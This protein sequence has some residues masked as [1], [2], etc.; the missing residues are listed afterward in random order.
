MK[1]EDKLLK[2]RKEKGLSQE[3]VADRLKVSRQTISKWETGQ[4]SPD[5]DKI[6]PLC[7]LY[8]ISSDE[9]LTGKKKEEIIKEEKE[10]ENMR[11]KGIGISVLLYFISTVLLLFFLAN[12]DNPIF[13]IGVFLICSGI[14]SY[15]LIYTLFRYKRDEEN[16]I[17]KNFDE[18]KMLIFLDSI[19]F[20]MN[21]MLLVEDRSEGN[22]IYNLNNFI[23]SEFISGVFIINLLILI[24]S[25]ISIKKAFKSNDNILLKVSFSIFSILNTYLCLDLFI[26]LFINL[27][28]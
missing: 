17:I 15:I 14:A 16:K 1:I 18:I 2:L 12:K 21:V 27:F 28:S 24:F 20:I 13:S 3:E 23:L 26:D 9:L 11:A 5:F 10:H 25:V 22:L 8:E 7:E 6:I 4:S 19:S